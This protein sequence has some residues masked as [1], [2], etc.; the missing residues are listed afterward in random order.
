MSQSKKKYLID[1][2]NNEG[3][4]YKRNYL[5]ISKFLVTVS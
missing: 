3:I 4:E 1:K 5:E 2:Q